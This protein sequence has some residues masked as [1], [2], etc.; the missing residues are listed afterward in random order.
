MLINQ[1]RF[2]LTFFKIL[3]NFPTDK[4]GLESSKPRSNRVKLSN[5]RSMPFTVTYVE[6]VV[7]FVTPAFS[8]SLSTL[9]RST[10]RM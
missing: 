3:A 7:C 1:L 10:I 4:N 2:G 9:E 6:L 8:A 5:V